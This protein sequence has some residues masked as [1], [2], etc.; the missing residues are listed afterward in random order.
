MLGRVWI[1][2]GMSLGLRPRDIPRKI[3]TLPCLDGRYVIL[4]TDKGLE[5]VSCIG[6]YMEHSRKLHL[7]LIFHHVGFIF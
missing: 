7:L 3:H 2:L 5:G 1:F 4:S 6:E